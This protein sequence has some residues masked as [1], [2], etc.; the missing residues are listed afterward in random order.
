MVM[1]GKSITTTPPTP[2]NFKMRKDIYGQRAHMSNC[3][4]KKIRVSLC[5]EIDICGHASVTKYTK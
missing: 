3:M 5:L 4:T 1:S 2:Y